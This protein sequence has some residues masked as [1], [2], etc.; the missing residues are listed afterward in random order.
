MLLFEILCF[1]G[2]VSLHMKHR[3]Y[4]YG[5]VIVGV[6]IFKVK[7][8]DTAANHISVCFSNQVMLKLVS[9]HLTSPKFIMT[10]RV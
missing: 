9:I 2:E 10:G 8:A 3:D 5:S 1:H 7:T 4:S 6:H